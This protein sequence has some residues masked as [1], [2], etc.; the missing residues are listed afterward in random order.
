VDNHSLRRI[1][2]SLLL[3]SLLLAL[4][5]QA[6]Q[7]QSD[8]VATSPEGPIVINDPPPGANNWSAP[9]ADQAVAR[10]IAE[11]RAAQLFETLEVPYGDQ[12]S[13]A[14][15]PSSQNWVDN[16]VIEGYASAESVN[17]GQSINLHIAA[18]S[19]V[20]AADLIVYRMGGINGIYY[21]WVQQIRNVNVSPHTVP[22]PNPTTGRIEANWPVS[23]TLQTGANWKSGV[24]LININPAGTTTNTSYIVFVVRND[25]V[26]AD[27]LYEV[28]FTTYQ[29]YNSWGGKSLYTYNS[30]GIPAVEVSYDRPYEHDNGVGLFFAGDYNMIH[31]LES[32]GYNV[33]Y[34]SSVD[35]HTNP[36]LMNNRKMLLSNFHDEYYSWQMFNNVTAWRDQGKHQAWFTSNNIYWQIRFAPS[37]TGV[38][39]RV[40]VCYKNA[41]NDPMSTSST[42]WLTTVLFR[43]P[44]VNRPE[45]QLLGIQFDNAMGFGEYFDYVVTNANHWVYEGTGLANGS[46]IPMLVG[47]EYDRVFSNGFTPPG[48]VVL[49]HSPAPPVY[50]NYANS[51]IYTAPSGAMIFAA[52]TNYWAYM[53]DGNWIWQVNPTVRRITTNILNRMI[54]T[55]PSGTPT[56]TL[57]PTSTSTPINTPTAGPSPTPSNTPTFTSTPT[58]TNTA[59]AVNTPTS[60]PTSGPVTTSFYRAI[61][62]GGSAVVIDGNNWEASTAPNY[63]VVGSPY[64]S[65]WVT[66]V[67]ATDANRAQMIRCTVQHWAQNI[68]LNSVPADT[69]DVYLYVWLDW[70]DPN[71]AVITYRLEGQIVEPGIQLTGA[72]TWRRLGPYRATITDGAIN[73][74]TSGGVIN[75]SGIEVYRVLPVGSTPTATTAATSTATFTTVPTST[76]T[77]TTAPTSTATFTTVPSSTPTFTTV[78]TSTATA[79]AMP[80][81]TATWTSTSVATGTPTSTAT[82]TTVPTSTATGT[83]VPTNTPTA[84]ATSTLVPTNTPTPVA[85]DLIFANGFEAGNLTG[86]TSVTGG[87]DVSATTGAALRGSYGARMLVNDN[88]AIYLRDDTPNAEARYRVR[89]YFD[90]NAV[91][92]AANDLFTMLRG[93]INTTSYAVQLEMRRTSTVYQ[94]RGRIMNDAGSWSSTSWTTVSDAPHYLEFDW[95]TATAAGANNGGLTFWIDGVQ[96]GSFTNID[97]DTHRITSVRLGLVAGV[98]S[99][100]RGTMYFDA[101]VSRRQTYIGPEAAA[102]APV[103]SETQPEITAPVVEVVPPESP[104]LAATATPFVSEAIYPNQPPIANDDVIAVPAG[105]PA[106]I[107]VWVNDSDPE[108]GEMVFTLFAQPLNGVVVDNGNGIFTYTSNPNFIGVDSF[109]YQTCDL[110]GLCDM[111]VVTVNVSA[112]EG[113]VISPEVPYGESTAVPPLPPVEGS[114]SEGS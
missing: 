103:T 55:Q 86:W 53:L 94:V 93:Y 82:F 84:T 70:A 38:A 46:T 28:P 61:N 90:P 7:A 60:T 108:N 35:V 102:P 100:T 91:T 36:G 47:Y 41:A 29:A 22:Q 74:T 32:Q 13:G 78:P 109:A 48:L 26:A 106:V 76:P 3:V 83:L 92:M 6:V 20:T 2:T 113:G 97:N 30:T 49:S 65:P 87:T 62:L 14:R 69:Y 73:V 89:F 16:R 42:P 1:A 24:Y 39:N 58:W 96:S 21:Q 8:P 81:N 11:R 114:G 4:G 17:A 95:R 34:A 63:T 110:E 88:N 75:V 5:L 18:K 68:V 45:N 15:A 59:T 44:P 40:I 33:T 19:P 104:I 98:D 43:D 56:A 31:W 54:G 37:T 27:I 9:E 64:C 71:P 50:G 23:Y 85:N 67:P 10:L 79:T 66:L 107:S 51:S 105:V 101:F 25:G 12:G 52:A 112:A 72:G 77:F 111:G 99:G 80:T 57:A